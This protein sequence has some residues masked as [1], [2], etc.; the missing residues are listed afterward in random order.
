[1]ALFAMVISQDLVAA[2]CLNTQMLAWVKS[3][4]ILQMYLTCKNC[5]LLNIVFLLIDHKENYTYRAY[6][7]KFIVLQNLLLIKELQYFV[8]FLFQSDR[9][10]IK[11]LII[12]GRLRLQEYTGFMKKCG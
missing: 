8:V 6:T 12:K 4:H 3:L 9:S 1:M 11:C 7:Q 5:H 2:C 10:A